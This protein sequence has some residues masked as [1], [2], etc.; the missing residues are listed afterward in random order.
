MPNPF[1]DTLR[2]QRIAHGLSVPDLALAAG[3]SEGFLYY[4]EAGMRRPSPDILKAL[5]QELG[6]DLMRNSAGWICPGCG[7][8]TP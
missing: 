6:G 7:Q 8:F 2:C 4:L 3:I 5:D 1:G